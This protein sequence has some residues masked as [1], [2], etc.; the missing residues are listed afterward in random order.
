MLMPPDP[1]RD[2]DRLAYQ[3]LGTA[4]PRA[5]MAVDAWREGD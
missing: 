5:V 2:F 4:A 1:F 3:V